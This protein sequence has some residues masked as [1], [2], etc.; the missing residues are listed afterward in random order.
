[1][2]RHRLI[3]VLLA[4][5]AGFVAAVPSRADP[6]ED[7]YKGRQLNVIVGYGTGGGFDVYARL[8][9]RHIGRF[10]PGSPGALVQNMPGAGSMLAM[11]HLYNLAPKDGST[12]AHFG[13]GLILTGALGGNPNARFDPRKLTWLGS[14]SRFA[15][16]AYV[17]VVGRGSPVQSIA[18]A[19]KADGAS[20]LLGG[21]AGGSTSN[22]VPLLLRHAI[23]LEFKLV[24]GYPD[25]A[26]LFLATERGEV[27]GRMVDLSGIKT[28]KPH[29]L[30]P[31]SGY[32]IILQYGRASRLPELAD[33]PTARELATSAEARAVIEL[34]ELP[35]SVSRPFAAPPGVPPD[36]AKALQSAFM[37]AHADPTFLAEARALGLDISPVSAARVLEDIDEINKAPPAALDFVRRLITGGTK[38]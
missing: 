24:A 4:A 22:D 14:S 28:I 34:A 33:V 1:M 26:A 37:A 2:A 15:G 32:R 21:S 7:F 23:G 11:N 36:R 25:S 20:F 16:D 38:N 35:Y 13:R 19:R 17:L 31:D 5:L 12:F 30:K 8:V 10:I 9:A 6:V 27:H 29:W 18:D 3:P